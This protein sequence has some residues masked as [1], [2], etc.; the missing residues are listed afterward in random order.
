[1]PGEMMQSRVSI[2]YG[3]NAGCPQ[4]QA[5]SH[6]WYEEFAFDLATRPR[7]IAKVRACLEARRWTSPAFDTRRWVQAFDTGARAI[8]EVARLRGTDRPMHV[9]MPARHVPGVG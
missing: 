3:Y 7:A 8:W 5:H 2:G 1:M 9:L 4:L 6:R